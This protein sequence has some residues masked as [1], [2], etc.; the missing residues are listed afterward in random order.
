MMPG[1]RGCSLTDGPE[2]PDSGGGTAQHTDPQ[3]DSVVPRLGLDENVAR[4]DGRDEVI[5]HFLFVVRIAL[6][7]LNREADTSRRLL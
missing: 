5:P 1:T 3:G 2:G 7:N 6:K 4:H